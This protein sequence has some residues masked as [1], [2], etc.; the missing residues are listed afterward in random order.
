[1][2]P[3]YACLEHR[4]RFKEWGEEG[5]VVYD[6]ASGDTHVLD[7]L[8]MELLH[9]LTQDPARKTESVRDELRGIYG[10]EVPSNVELSLARLE[11]VGLWAGIQT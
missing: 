7:P 4:F 6:I 5:T 3:W 11:E 1:M 2:P 9:M 8:A 10:G